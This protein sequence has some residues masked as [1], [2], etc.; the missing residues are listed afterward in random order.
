[1]SVSQ[2]GEVEEAGEVSG[3]VKA[4]RSEGRHEQRRSE[5]LSALVLYKKARGAGEKKRTKESVDPSIVITA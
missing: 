2:T 1:L 3:G 4:L 5:A